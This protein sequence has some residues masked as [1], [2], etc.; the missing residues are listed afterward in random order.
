MKLSRY[1]FETECDEKEVLKCPK[2]KS[3]A[4]L[5]LPRRGTY[6]V[7]GYKFRPAGIH[8]TF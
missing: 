6:L 2:P 4:S 1:P 7:Y 3:K 5:L 8:T